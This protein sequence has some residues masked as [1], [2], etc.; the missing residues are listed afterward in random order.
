MHRG[1]DKL[2]DLTALLRRLHS[3]TSG[4]TSSNPSRLYGDVHERRVQLNSVLQL[5]ETMEYRDLYG[6]PV[7]F[8]GLRDVIGQFPFDAPLRVRVE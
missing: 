7:I 1:F 2:G 5:V 6:S 8:R 3:A 4:R